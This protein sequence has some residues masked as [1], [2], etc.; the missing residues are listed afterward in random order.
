LAAIFKMLLADSQ[1]RP[2]E[3]RLALALA[4]TLLPFV[5]R[6]LTT[7]PIFQF[8]G[9]AA[10]GKTRTADRFGVLLYGESVA[11]SAT[12][13]ALR[14]ER[15]ALVILDD[16]ENLSP[17]LKDL[18]RRSATGTRYRSARRK[19]SKFDVESSGQIDS[20]YVLTAIHTPTDSPLLTRM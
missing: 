9:S 12:E 6:R 5:R 17:W 4:I 15:E 3:G 8:A 16:N 20:I 19:L 11:E 14:R 7:R 13:A 18:L 2:N 10:S 1:A